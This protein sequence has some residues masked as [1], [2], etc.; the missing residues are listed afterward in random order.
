MP[1]RCTD[2][3]MRLWSHV[4][5]N[6]F[7]TLG[8]LFGALLLLVTAQPAQ[9]QNSGFQVNRYEPTAAG[10]WS[11]WVDHPWYSKTRYFAGGI[12]LNYSHNPLIYGYSD[13]NG[14]FVQTS[15]IISH[16]L[17]GHLDLA[18]SFLDRVLITLS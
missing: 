6:N 11:F 10:E 12:T 8:F 18:G 14:N 7:K 9:A 5:R 2:L 15:T 3:E 16:Q 4:M 13:N 1:A 17:I